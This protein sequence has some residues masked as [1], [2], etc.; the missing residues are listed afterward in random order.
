MTDIP[1]N[2]PVPDP[3]LL[4]TAALDREISHLRELVQAE[5]K[6]DVSQIRALEQAHIDHHK[7]LDRLRDSQH[8]LVLAHI[9]ALKELLNEALAARDQALSAALSAAK[10]A[11]SKAEASTTKQVEGQGQRFEVEIKAIKDQLNDVKTN[12]G[13]SSGRVAGKEY[14]WGIMI[15]GAMLL[16]AIVGIFVSR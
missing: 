10:E 3:T 1:G 16:A 11:T 2:I 13:T 9:A 7:S 5:R 12:S 6:A 4:T 15:L 8:S 14:A